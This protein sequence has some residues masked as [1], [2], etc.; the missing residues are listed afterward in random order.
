MSRMPWYRRSKS[1]RVRAC[2]YRIHGW[3]EAE[4]L[5]CEIQ[6]VTPAWLG[7]PFSTSSNIA[8]PGGWI[9]RGG[10]VA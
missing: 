2:L 6:M 4:E 8:W 3:E 5:D 10:T 1:C 9:P 7:T